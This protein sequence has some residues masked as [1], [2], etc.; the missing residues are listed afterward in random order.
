MRPILWG[1]ILFFIGM[2]G[3]IAFSIIGGIGGAI[4]GEKIQ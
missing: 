3:W 4:T 1:V 2:I